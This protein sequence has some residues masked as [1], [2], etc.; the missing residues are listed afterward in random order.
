MMRGP[1]LLESGGLWSAYFLFRSNDQCFRVVLEGGWG[2]ARGRSQGSWVIRVMVTTPSEDWQ[3]GVDPVILSEVEEE[4]LREEKEE[5]T[6]SLSP[7]H[8]NKTKKSCR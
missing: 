3:K 1:T 7:E 4:R 6:G 5:R 2:V 8:G